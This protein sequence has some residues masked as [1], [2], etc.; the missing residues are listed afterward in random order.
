MIIAKRLVILFGTLF[1]NML[2]KQIFKKDLTHFAN[3]D[4]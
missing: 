1:K 3:I 2:K 4:K